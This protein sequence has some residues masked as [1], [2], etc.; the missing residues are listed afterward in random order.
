MDVC[1]IC[2][3]EIHH[4]DCIGADTEVHWILQPH[5]RFYFVIHPPINNSK[6]AYC[7]GNVILE[8]KPY[9]KRNHDIVDS[10]SSLIAAPLTDKEV[11]RS[12]TW[13]TVRYA[14]KK[15]KEVL[16]I[17]RNGKIIKRTK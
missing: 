2:K 3:V 8:P 16:I 12:G 13:A 6:R 11:I 4:G 9:L 5:S 10:T 14:L 1:A 7:S 15:G 17:Q